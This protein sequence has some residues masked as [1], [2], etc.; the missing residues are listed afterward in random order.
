MKTLLGDDMEAAF[1]QP[2]VTGGVEVMLGATNDPTFGHVLAFGAGGTLVEVL[3]DIAFRIHPLTPNDA[4]DMI[5]E[6][7]CAKMLDGVRGAAP[8]DK[9]ALREAIMRLS[10]LISICPEIQELDI[11]PLKV[12]EKGAIALDARVRVEQVAPAPPSRRIAY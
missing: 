5:S 7:R 3:S 12:L 8:S 2:M 6:L 10:A 1:V 11:N 4:E 9:P